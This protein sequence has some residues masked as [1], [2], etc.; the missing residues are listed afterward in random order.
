MNELF[1]APTS[2]IAAV[3]VVLVATALIAVALIALRNRTMF[4]MGLR[5]L[6]RRRAQTALIIAG[7]TLSTLVVTAAFVT[8]DTINHSFTKSSYDVLQRTDLDISFNGTRE[9]TGDH[10]VAVD[11]R[12][13]AVDA[14][15]IPE[16]ES[17]FAGDA[18]IEGF[19]PLRF[20]TAAAVN[21]RT[22]DAVAA[23]QLAGYD[24]ERLGRLGG[25]HLAN[26]GDADLAI[27]ERQLY[28]SQRAADD[29][30]LERG[31]I[32]TLH[33]AG[34]PYPFEVAGIVND[35]IA[36]GVLGYSYAD[37]PG[38]FAVPAATLDSLFGHPGA[39]HWIGVALHGGVT[40]TVDR[41]AAAQASLTAYLEGA[42][43][44]V[45]TAAGLEPG[46]PVIA[47]TLKADAIE[48]GES[49]GQQFVI[50][51]LALGMFAVAAGAL[52]V[53]MIF[54]M[55]AA[56]RKAE[57]GITRAVGAQRS[58]LVQAFLSEGM[59]YALVSGVA[60]V[61]LG[62][63]ASLALTVGLLKVTG[64]DEFSIIS[65]AVSTTSLVMGYCLGVA[66]TFVTVLFSSL[67]VSHV[68]IVAAIRGTADE[69][70][71]GRP[72]SVSLKWVALGILTLPIVPLG[73]YLLVHRGLGVRRSLVLAP[74]GIVAGLALAWLGHGSG[75]LF[76]FATGI[77]I[78][79]VC[80]AALVVS[81][82]APGRL[83]WTLGGV[84]ILAYWCLP[85]SLHDR[86]FGTFD[87]DIEMFVVSG[88]MVVMGTTLVIVFN[89]SLLT[90]LVGSK[91][92]SGYRTAMALLGVAVILV[93][94]GVV[95]GNAGQGVGQLSFLA[96][97]VLV[98]TA[99]F[100]SVSVRFSALR[101]AIKMAVAYP[102]SNRFRTGMTL[103]MFSLVVFSMTTLSILLANFGTLESG[104]AARG[105]LDV[106]M[107]AESGAIPPGVEAWLVAAG[108]DG[109]SDVEG[110]G[111]VTLARPNQQVRNVEGEFEWT[112]LP[113][114]GADA[115]F[116]GA[117]EPALDARAAGF[118]TDAEV[119]A[120]VA[121]NSGYA[122]LDRASL[123]SDFSEFDYQSGIKV[124][125]DTFAPF[126]VEIRDEATGQ[127]ATVT[128]IGG[129]K[130]RL[131][132]ASFTGVYVHGG[133]YARVFGEPVY[134]QAY[135]RLNQGADAA[136][137]ASG[138]RSK[139]ATSGVDAEAVSETL[140]KAQAEQ[141]AFNRMFQAFM[142]LGLF[143]G[144]AGLGV[145]AMRSVVERRQQ[146]GMLRAIGF[147]RGTVT[148][149]FLFESGFVA[150]MG[151]LAGISGGMVIARNL[152]TSPV[153]TGGG[154]QVAFTV[155]WTEIAVLA[156]VALACSL[157]MTWWPSRS[158]SRVA[159][160]EALRYE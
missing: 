112:T 94:L 44:G 23:V 154:E 148:T 100:A 51:F 122:L 138:I 22:G 105:N 91:S 72:R 95:L 140:D 57:M 85:N 2:M 4:R 110:A 131:P 109:A 113:V 52:L 117:L 65:P 53:F 158:A 86:L 69:D 120:A 31:D 153:M 62:V 128:I 99:A 143:V 8:G 60:G 20:E 66:L 142:A 17:A 146:I 68:N 73:V 116:F 134:G 93:M 37:V 74:M 49:N 46:R 64:G 90:R 14:S 70:P 84:G 136:E 124:D 12:Q 7:L 101:P 25:L 82:G 81:L 56:E 24:P 63:L 1:G 139:L 115:G 155:P 135:L 102:L 41:T 98:A 32:V 5:N 47:E 83:A 133:L 111:R 10:G 126:D 156:L 121:A 119:L 34:T 36:S 88:I 160:A 103:A 127:T 123:R 50:F 58:H 76:L 40:G 30:D 75:T 6:P 96:A 16:L 45:F 125:G 38:G 29:L 71:V 144:I 89:A 9:L 43:A 130:S 87:F 151:I 28:A 152:M 80:I 78:V 129:L 132:S 13:A 11:G 159:V 15:V 145:I 35:E 97:L 3:L 67:K 92:E 39:I 79:P 104:D 21:S 141:R 19:I 26:G 77:S 147:R 137:V 118:E 42:G 108:V 55:L 107:T 54:V 27:D 149:M 59:A 33:V 150:V 157:V 114:R 18:T 61:G 48:K 106:S